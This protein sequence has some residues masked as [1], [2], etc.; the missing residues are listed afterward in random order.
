[1]K[2]VALHSNVSFDRMRAGQLAFQ[3]PK[4]Q[5]TEWFVDKYE[6]DV[7]LFDDHHL[8]EHSKFKGVKIALILEC[9]SIYDDAVSHN[10][11][12]FHPFNWIEENY[13]HFDYV[14]SPYLKLKELFGEKFFWI[15]AVHSGI[16]N[17][18]VGMYEKSRLLS[19]TAS[20]KTW[21]TGHKLRHELI[22]RFRGKFEFDI[23]GSGY[24]NIIDTRADGRLISLA[25]YYFNVAIMNSMIDDFFTEN[26]CDVFA[27]GTIPI[28]WATENLKNHF[29]P[30]GFIQF[31]TLD[32]FEQIVPTLTPELY[33]ERRR[34]VEENIEIVRNKFMNWMNYIPDTYKD[35]LENL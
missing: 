13:M 18:E 25:P 17:D 1:M 16:L 32:E 27:V 4:S 26:I 14:M 20:F 5:T 11:N 15:P 8:R 35:I 21:T 29:N 28:V 33:E 2:K 23:Y 24:N 3:P 9:P 30:D 31:K 22:N 7:H 34:A 19:V 10:S 6:A 12:T